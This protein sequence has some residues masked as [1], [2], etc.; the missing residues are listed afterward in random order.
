MKK[1]MLFIS[2]MM[3]SCIVFSIK[4]HADLG[5][6]PTADIKVVGIDE[7]YYFDIFIYYDFLIEPIEGEELDWAI[8]QYYQDDYPFD[9]L[10]GY[11]DEDGY[12]SRTLGYNQAAPAHIIKQVSDDDIYHVGYFSAPEVFKI[13][14][15]TESGQLILSEVVHRQLFTSSMTYDL[16]SVDLSFNQSGVGIV[17][18]H[19]PYGHMSIALV[20]RVI[21]TVLVELLILIFIFKYRLKQSLWLVGFTNAVT[22]SLLTMG[23]MAGYYFWGSFFGLIGMLLLGELVVFIV[24][25]LIYGIWLKE[26]NRKKAILYGFIANLITL[27]LT[28]FTIPLI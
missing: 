8:E 20:I 24:E 12:A 19:I 2:L 22:Q 21:L 10:N 27:I 26:F 5:P 16:S 28:I 6:K 7:P 9:L 11:Q 4:S 3:I 23:I 17:S 25:M 13:A 18:E 15:L 14:I 1:L